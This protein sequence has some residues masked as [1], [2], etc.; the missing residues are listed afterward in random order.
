MKTGKDLLPEDKTKEFRE[1]RS[2]HY[3]NV[4]TKKLKEYNFPEW[5]V[6][7]NEKVLLDYTIPIFS[8]VLAEYPMLCGMNS[9]WQILYEITKI[10]WVFW[11]THRTWKMFFDEIIEEVILSKEQGGLITPISE[12]YLYKFK[13]FREY[14]LRY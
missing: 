9:E 7:L 1:V 10:D 14:K 3:H 13:N 2:I 5:I 6:C 8:R 11:K 12:E 4:I